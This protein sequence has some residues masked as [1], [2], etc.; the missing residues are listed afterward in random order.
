[1]GVDE[2]R[3]DEDEELAQCSVETRV[4][5]T[6]VNNTSRNAVNPAYKII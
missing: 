6:L 4:R 2:E 1:V 3:E 5:P